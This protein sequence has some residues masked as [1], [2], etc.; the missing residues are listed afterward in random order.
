MN[1]ELNSREDS[2]KRNSDLEILLKEI[3][4][5]LSLVEE[6]QLEQNED[7][8][9]VFVVGALRS[10]TTLLMQWFANLDQ[11]AYPTNML[12]RFFEAP[13][14]GSKIQLLLS[15]EK[16][17]FRNE[18]LDFN[19]SVNF[20]SENGKTNGA[21]SPNEFW[22]F[23]RRFLPFKELDYVPDQE[24]FEK[25]NIKLLKKQ[26][27]GISNVFSKPLVMKAMILNYNIEFLSKVFPKSIFIHTMR[28]P[29]ENI[30]S[31]L[32]ARKKQ[33]GKIEEWYSFKIP[34]YEQLKDLNPYYQ[35]AGQIH[36]T[37]KAIKNSLKIIEPHRRITL[38]YEEFCKSPIC[39]YENLAQNLGSMGIKLS[40]RYVGPSSFNKTRTFTNNSL[41]EIAYQHFKDR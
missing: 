3:N 20:T 29:L 10:G 27:Y 23:W 31:A 12:S 18:I 15:D 24:L 28:N 33:Y 5:D 30:E 22:Y 41:I 34:E 2:F 13:I 6:K 16:Y 40:D 35:V 11:F 26:L 21:L 38:N 4:Q 7:R 17:N 14:I 32:S 1:D 25:V 19:K 9:I 39:F 36:Y 8:P 37:N